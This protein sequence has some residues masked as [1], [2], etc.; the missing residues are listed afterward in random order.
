MRTAPLSFATLS[1]ASPSLATLAGHARNACLGLV[2]LAAL[3]V[4]P[5]AQAVSNGD[6][7]AGLKEALSR[8]A[9]V[10]VGQLG[11]TNGFLGDSRV[12]IPLPGALAQAEGM[13]RMA[14]MGKQ[15]DEVVD[16]MNHAAE[17]AVVEAKP[18]LLKAVKG[19]SV[20]D[21]QGVLT[22]GDHAATDY[23]RQTTSGELTQKFL[24]I[25]KKA[26][27]RL[28]VKPQYDALAGRAAGL[29][30]VDAKDASLDD[31]V[32]RKALDGLFLMIAE[33][34]KAIRK[35]PVGTGSALLQKVFGG[36]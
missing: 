2:C 12:K 23:F 8:G 26:T 15:A 35:D 30:L 33:Q 34:E 14:G 25:V 31:Y 27:D 32:T 1:F 10:A 7:V 17:Q 4:A 11:K 13:L 36:L 16:A 28:Q 19:M 29:G 3:A 22:G 6:A 21:A 9:E 18:V 20:K 24:P 5:A